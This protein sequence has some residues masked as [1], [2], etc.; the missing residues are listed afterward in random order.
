MKNLVAKKDTFIKTVNL[1][2]KEKIRANGKPQREKYNFKI[3]EERVHK[4]H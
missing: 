1:D 2:L 4:K 3:T